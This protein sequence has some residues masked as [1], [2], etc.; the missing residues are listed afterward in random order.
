MTTP[1]QQQGIVTGKTYRVEG[2]QPGYDEIN[3]TVKVGTL[4]TLARDDGSE[5]PYFWKVDANG[6]IVN[7][8]N[9]KEVIKITQTKLVE[10]KAEE[11]EPTDYCVTVEEGQT[12]FIIRKRLSLAEI[13]AVLKAAGV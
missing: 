13:Y 10:V 3:A 12:Q 1:A 5:L 9:G 4:V 7:Q 2:P 6:K 8:D 11:D